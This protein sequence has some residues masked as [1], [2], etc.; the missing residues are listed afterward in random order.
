MQ[1]WVRTLC[2]P[3]AF[4]RQVVIRLTLAGTIISLAAAAAS[5]AV[6]KRQIETSVF[7]MVIESAEYFK[8]SENRQH[9]AMQ[10]GH[11]GS[12][13]KRLLY[14]SPFLAI[15]IFDSSGQ[16][17][18]EAWKAFDTDFRSLVDDHRHT[19]LGTGTS[20]RNWLQLGE[21]QV[22][23]VVIPLAS[24]EKNPVVYLEGVYP[25]NEPLQQE[26]DA[27]IRN[28][29]LFAL[30]SA[31]VVT[32]LLYP[33]LISLMRLSIQ[34]SNMLLDS[35]VEL[36][37]TLGSA[38]AK[39][40]SDTDSHNY[41]VTMYAVRL[42]EVLD[43]PHSEMQGL[44]TGAFLHDIGKIGIPDAILLKPD[45]LNESELSI[46]KQHVV[47]GQQII[48]NNHWLRKSL[49]VIGGHHEK[50]DGSG[51][52]KGLLA[53]M[54]PLSARIFAVVDVFDALT[55]VRPYKEAF[56][57][58]MAKEILE[59]GRGKHFDPVIVSIFLGHVDGLFNEIGTISHERLE[60]HLREVT[61]KYFE[62]SC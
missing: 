8:V 12:E 21:R 14:S 6:E 58:E 57:L 13:L 62:R 4:R 7:S 61:D 42:A 38:I 34:S 44:I 39:R 60:E 28:S 32:L 1:K 33:V 3:M 51:Y 47:L 5:Y 30:A 25:I 45:R 35:N 9:L 56:T 11:K 17:Q 48:A 43:R 52:P 27:R 50:Y 53:E 16:M 10:H 24:D 41:R 29:V 19:F 2:A 59:E 54:I 20:H 26:L 18:A 31:L 22:I 15:R 49:E 23:Q 40:D 55:S 36:I 46:M 37:G